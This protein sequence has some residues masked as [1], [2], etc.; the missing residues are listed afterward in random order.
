M[1]PSNRLN[2]PLFLQLFV[3]VL[4]LH[5]S[6]VHF[7]YLGWAQSGGLI[8]TQDTLVFFSV[9]LRRAHIATKNYISVKSIDT[10]IKLGAT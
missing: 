5:P 6:S 2:Q 8:Q 1:E 7:R 3:S 4:I 9:Q 10:I